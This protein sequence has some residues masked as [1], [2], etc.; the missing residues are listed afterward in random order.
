[1]K[2]ILLGFLAMVMLVIGLVVAVPFAGGAFLPV[3]HVASR[4]VTLNAPPDRVWP[5][6]MASFARGNNAGAFSI[7]EIDQPYRLVTRVTPK[8]RF[9]GGTWTYDLVPVATGTQ[10]TITERGEI[11]QPAFR[12]LARF[13]FGYTA[14]IDAALGE[15]KRASARP[16]GRG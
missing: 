1:M 2:R 5:L 7:A 13:V 11:Y 14:T 4:S 8:E 3:G 15:I 10:L 12:F 16:N 9:F 6:V